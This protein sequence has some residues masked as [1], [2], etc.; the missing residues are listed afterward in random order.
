M[1]DGQPG[2]YTIDIHRQLS[3]LAYSPIEGV[4]SCSPRP[5]PKRL[6][7]IYSQ[8]AHIHTTKILHAI[9]KMTDLLTLPTDVTLHTPF[10]ICMTATITIAHL[11]ACKYVFKGRQLYIARERV[12]VAIGALETLGQIWPRAKNVVREIKTIAKELLFVGPEDKVDVPH[13][14]SP[15]IE[16]VDRLLLEN[17]VPEPDY[18]SN[19]DLAQYLCL[20]GQLPIVRSSFSEDDVGPNFSYTVDC[21]T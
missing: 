2:S 7:G 18:F 9:E 15:P 6:E 14:V 20:D 17:S 4:S 16:A 1:T 21:Q 19:I 5:P 10:T 8:E 12:R 11:S 3:D 13:Q